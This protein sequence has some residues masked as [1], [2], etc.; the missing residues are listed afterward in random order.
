MSRKTRALA[1]ALAALCALALPACGQESFESAMAR[2][3]R[4]MQDVESMHVDMSAE[5]DMSLS[6]EGESLELPLAMDM[7]MDS[8]TEPLLAHAD[9]DMS[10]LGQD[11][12]VEYYIEQGGE[13]L[14]AYASADG[15]SWAPMEL[16]EASLGQFSAADSV[17]FY[18]RCASAFEKAGEEE[19]NGSTASRYEGEVPADMLSEALERSG[20]YGML[21]S[22]GLD[23]SAGVSGSEAGLELTIWLDEETGLPVRYEIDMAA[24][25]DEL[26]E[27]ALAA[28]S[29]EIDVDIGEACVSVTLSDFNGIDA[30]EIPEAAS[31]A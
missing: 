28:V 23:E 1:L 9:M 29:M 3:I 12:S 7:S 16:D 13:G 15:A 21:E 30:I 4:E 5:I 6:L 2:A 27:T 17:A 8:Y 31:G 25:M 18:L 24:L 20:A 10:L 11:F 26:M 14:S 19:I 22:V